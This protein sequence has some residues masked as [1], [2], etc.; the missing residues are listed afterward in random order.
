MVDEKSSIDSS[1]LATNVSVVEVSSLA[2]GN[3]ILCIG[4]RVELD[5]SV[6]S[7]A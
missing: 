5:K 3:G 1:R 6:G 2:L 7:L 4:V